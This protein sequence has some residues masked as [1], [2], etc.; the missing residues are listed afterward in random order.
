MSSL[1][2]VLCMKPQHGLCILIALSALSFLGAC[3]SGSGG[4]PPVPMDPVVIDEDNATEVAAGMPM[5]ASLIEF[6]DFMGFETL[7][8]EG[9]GTFD[10]PDGGSITASFQVDAAPVG[11]VSTGDRFAVS[12]NDCMLDPASTM[13]GGIVI[14][15][16]T[17]TG[18]WTV[19]DVWEVDIGFEINNLTFSSGPATGYFDGSWSQNA[20]FDT[21][22]K[23]FALAGDFATTLNDGTGYQSAVLDGLDLSW[24][25]DATAAESTYSVDGTFASTALGGS[26]TVTTL[27]PFVLR[28]VD[29]YPYT[30]SIQCT[31]AAGSAL[32]M[33]AVDE[34][35]V[36]LAVDV[37]GDGTPEVTVNTTWDALEE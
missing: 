8:A 32:T 18:D 19:D 15:F 24:S 3:S 17:I 2:I 26:V 36:Q 12:F 6:Q 5:A 31:G 28:D 25:Y 33:T 4:P 13:N 14:D 29:L 9:T 16:E 37:D 27:S 21:G 7:T 1:P 20:T 30:G 10:C 11:E 23:T 35:F 34:T 22:D